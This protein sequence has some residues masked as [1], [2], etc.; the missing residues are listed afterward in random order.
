MKQDRLLTLHRAMGVLAPRLRPFKPVLQPFRRLL[1]R[2]LDGAVSRRYPAGKLMFAEQNGRHWWLRPE[3]AF[4]GREQEY[5]TVLWLQ[6]VVRPGMQVIDVGANVGQ[7][8]LEMAELV[9]PTG[10]VVAI[11]PAEGNLR[12][13]RD[14]LNGNGFA[15]RVEVLAAVGAEA[16]GGVMSFFVAGESA[17]AVGSGHSTVARALEGVDRH[18]VRVAKVSIDGVCRE[19]NMSPAVIK[20]DVE[21]AELAV[22]EGARDTLERARPTLRIGFHPFAF[23]DVLEA[24]DRLRQLLAAHRYRLEAPANGPLGLE[25]YVATPQ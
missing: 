3:V 1:Q 14:H 13:L 8:S 7:M 10:R 6:Q 2:V 24:S 25:E 12:I 20:I 21:G 17:D 19:R 4:R 18:E 15:D 23:A 11:E 16:H 9:G 22:L 5:D